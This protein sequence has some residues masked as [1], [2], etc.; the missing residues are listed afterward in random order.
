VGE[1]TVEVRMTP[2]LV[3]GFSEYVSV[4]PTV[5]VVHRR[6]KWRINVLQ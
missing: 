5:I 6:R 1:E 4:C 3:V 2:P